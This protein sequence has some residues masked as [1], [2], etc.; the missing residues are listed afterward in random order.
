[1]AKSVFES[2]YS[3]ASSRGDFEASKE[4]VRSSQR[5]LDYID[6]KWDRKNRDR[7]Q[8]FDAIFKGLEVAD[9]MRVGI[10]ESKKFK[11]N[12]PFAQ[13]HLQ[14]LYGTEDVLEKVERG[15]LD[16]A[17]DYILNRPPSYKFGDKTFK[18]QQDYQDLIAMGKRQRAYEMGLDLETIKE[19]KPDTEDDSSISSIISNYETENIDT[20]KD[21]DPLGILDDPFGDPSLWQEALI[22]EDKTEDED[23]MGYNINQIGG[24]SSPNFSPSIKRGR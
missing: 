14:K 19:T 2:S 18:T 11:E 24:G 13:K 1:M 17:L 21:N 23:F 16:T 12:I 3:A 4:R 7:D 15:K 9:T 6:K 8:R 20:E 22:S 10:E 5:T